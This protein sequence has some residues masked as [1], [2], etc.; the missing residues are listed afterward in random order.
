MLSGIARARR[1]CDDEKFVVW[2]AGSS[3][4]MRG[5][6]ALITRRPY[7]FYLQRILRTSSELEGKICV[8]LEATKK[9]VSI[10]GAGCSVRF[11]S[12]VLELLYVGPFTYTMQFEVLPKD[13]LV[14][15]RAKLDGLMDVV[16]RLA[17][18]VKV[19]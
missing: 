19:Y 11:G 3:R 13:S 15:K 1:C 17:V 14:N 2:I 10:I 16:T 6:P 9:R 5:R 7:I 4:L 8:L 18:L 12:D